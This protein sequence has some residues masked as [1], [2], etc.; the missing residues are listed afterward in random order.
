MYICFFEKLLI[1]I[2]KIIII[3]RGYWFLTNYYQNNFYNHF[4]NII[5]FLIS[6]IFF[7]KNIFIVLFLIKSPHLKTKKSLI[8]NN[9]LEKTNNNS[10]YNKLILES[11]HHLIFKTKYIF[12]N[13]HSYSVGKTIEQIK[14]INKI[15]AIKREKFLILDPSS[16]TLIFPGD[17]LLIIG[18]PMELNISQQFLEQTIKN[19]I[20]FESK[21]LKLEKIIINKNSA[22]QG[23]SINDINIKNHFFILIISISRKYKHILFPLHSETLKLNDTILI[24]GEDVYIKIFKMIFKIK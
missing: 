17:S 21:A 12:I 15:I 22:L 18:L 16:N 24:L 4:R 13:H 3:L 1:I 10:I 11:K 14:I 7:I 2:I 8:N 5:I 19:I 23:K 20:L 9:S 6:Y